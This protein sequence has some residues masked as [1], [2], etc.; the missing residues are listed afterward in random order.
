MNKMMGKSIFT[1]AL[2]LVLLAIPAFAA[3]HNKSVTVDAGAE[4]NGASTVNGSITIGDNA[5]IDGDAE[6]VNGSIKVGSGVTLGEASTVNGKISIA[7][8]VRMGSVSTVNGAVKVGA[9]TSIDGGVDA[10]NGSIRLDNGASVSGGVSNVNGKIELSGSTI[11]GDV[12]TVNGDLRL[13]D[14]A[15]VRGDVVVEKASGWGWGKND[16]PKVIVGPGSSVDGVIR[17][18]REVELFISESARVR[19]VEGVMS[20]DDAVRFSGERP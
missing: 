12:T 4:A 11:G 20:M 18:E 2:L 9:V 5:V 6:T 7:D 15:A 16:R 8:N 13:T 10:V 14:G 3:D 17:L 19:G 1:T